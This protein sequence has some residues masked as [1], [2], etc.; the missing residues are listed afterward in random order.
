MLFLASPLPPLSLSLSHPV[1]CHCRRRRPATTTAKN[2]KYI[3]Y[4]RFVD[5]LENALKAALAT[6]EV[7]G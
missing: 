3:L 1:L 6:T 2:T 4:N 5:S 7:G